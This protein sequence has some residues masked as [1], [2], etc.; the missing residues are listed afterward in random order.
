MKQHKVFI[1][2]TERE[3]SRPPTKAYNCEKTRLAVYITCRIMPQ[4]I[5]LEVIYRMNQTYS[6]LGTH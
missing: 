6:R 1:I 4:C 3:T 5:K 2:N